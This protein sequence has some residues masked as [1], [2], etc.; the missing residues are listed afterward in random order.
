MPFD[1]AVPNARTLRAI[2]KLETP[3]KRGKLTR[4]VRTNAMA[5]DILDKRSNHPS[6]KRV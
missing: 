3:A 2:E 4:H 5:A 6:K 1:V